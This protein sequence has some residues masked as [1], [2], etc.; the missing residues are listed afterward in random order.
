MSQRLRKQLF[1]TKMDGKPLIDEDKKLIHTPTCS[2]ELRKLNKGELTAVKKSVT[3]TI[4][5][6]KPFLAGKNRF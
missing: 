1:Y 2:G 4:R 3:A 6:I 5:Y